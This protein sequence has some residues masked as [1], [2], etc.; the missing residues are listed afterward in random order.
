MTHKAGYVTIIGSPNV[1]KSTLMNVM[2]GEKLSIITHKAQTT[3]HRIMGIFSG[4][5]FPDDL[6]GYSGYHETALPAP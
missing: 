3:R 1:G 2:I 5:G 6:F 4:E